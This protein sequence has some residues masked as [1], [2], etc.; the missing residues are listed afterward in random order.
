MS[1]SAELGLLHASEPSP[2]CCVA[3]YFAVLRAHLRCSACSALMLLCSFLLLSAPPFS[4]LPLSLLKGIYPRDTWACLIM[5]C[6][7]QSWVMYELS[8]VFKTMWCTLVRCC[9]TCTGGSNKQARTIDKYFSFNNRFL[10]S[11]RIDLNIASL[12]S[13]LHH[14]LIPC[15]RMLRWWLSHLETLIFPLCVQ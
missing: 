15:K 3:V 11:R 8:F 4:V 1:C 6:L 2:L 10:F 13:K 14:E 9:V 12:F 5:L 7:P